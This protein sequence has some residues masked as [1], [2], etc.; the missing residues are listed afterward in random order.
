MGM[1]KEQL[2]EPTPN[3]EELREVFSEAMEGLSKPERQVIDAT[4][5]QFCED[6]S[7]EY[8]PDVVS[9]FF[10]HV[11]RGEFFPDPYRYASDPG[12][13]FADCLSECDPRGLIS[14][15][16]FDQ[17]VD[18]VTDLISDTLFNYTSIAKDEMLMREE[19]DHWVLGGVGATIAL[20]DPDRD[21]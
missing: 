12:P 13:A 1:V 17:L 16:L 6:F 18:L 14:E 11:G 10:T 19:L 2:D 4:I 7:S 20:K 9:G 21:H 8:P 15:G 3:P 5:K